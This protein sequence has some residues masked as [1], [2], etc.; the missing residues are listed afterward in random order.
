MRTNLVRSIVFVSMLAMCAFFAGLFWTENSSSVNW[1]FYSQPH[2]VWAHRGLVDLNVGVYENSIEAFKNAEAAG[3]KGIEIDIYFDVPS[4]RFIVS[5]APPNLKTSNARLYLQ[6]VLKELDQDTFIWV[7]FK[8]L[9]TVNTIEAAVVTG[10]LS[11]LLLRSG[12]TDTVIVESNSATRLSMLN[13]DGIHT[14]YSL[15]IEDDLSSF[16]F[17]YKMMKFRYEIL[18]YQLLAVSLSYE[19]YTD[20]VRMF[21]P[22]VSYFLATINDKKNLDQY[23]RDPAVKVMLS[24]GKFYDMQWHYDD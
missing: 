15:N 14:L 7:D 22:E 16:E 2:K 3:A 21:L 17:L 10:E 20:R 8:N 9:A 24:D 6:T 19:Q 13:E 4:K 12:R 11:S 18:V 23:G 5:H 1:V